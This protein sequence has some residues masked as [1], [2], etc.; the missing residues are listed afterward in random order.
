MLLEGL[1]KV[2]NLEVVD[3]SITAN[4]FINKDHIIFKGHFPDNPV[5]PG[6]CMMQ[7]IKEI[8]EN[9]VKKKLFTQSANN[10][11]FM[12]IINPFN[13]PELELK[14]DIS[15]TDE[16]YKVKNTS[17]FEDTIALKSTTNFIVK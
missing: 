3:N 9:V 6:V 13:T 17:K 8:T 5:M 7:I 2:N 16:G 10:I 1:Y 4:I 11:K 15:E 12:A 14:L